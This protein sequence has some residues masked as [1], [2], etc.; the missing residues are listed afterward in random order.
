MNCL[1]D[2]RNSANRQWSDLGHW[3]QR[4]VPCNHEF[5]FY[6]LVVQKNFIGHVVKFILLSSFSYTCS[7]VYKI[8][9]YTVRYERHNHGLLYHPLTATA[10][11]YHTSRNIN[12]Y[13]VQQSQLSSNPVQYM[14][15]HRHDHGLW[16]SCLRFIWPWASELGFPEGFIL[17]LQAMIK[18]THEA[19]WKYLYMYNH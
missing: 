19:F 4:F 16:W 14:T 13:L 12:F 9:N 11:V 17:K 6:G 15:A 8:S 10:W 2:C 1:N 5:P 3:S 7:L 18:S